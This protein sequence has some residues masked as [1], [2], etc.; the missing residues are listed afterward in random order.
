M[1]LVENIGEFMAKKILSKITN[2]LIQSYFYLLCTLKNY[3]IT[4]LHLV[5]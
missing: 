3:K 2:Q 5:L 4:V 1:V